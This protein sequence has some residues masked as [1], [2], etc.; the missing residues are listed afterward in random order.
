MGTKT[1][2]LFIPWKPDGGH[3]DAFLGI[4]R[5]IM[6]GQKP[7]KSDPFAK[8]SDFGRFSS[9]KS[10]SKTSMELYRNSDV[11]IDAEIY[12]HKYEP[13]PLDQP[14]LDAFEDRSLQR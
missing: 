11:D 5:A 2:Y 13:T 12:T 3:T 9:R 14:K 6:L 10:F 7:I 4:S 1:I 8:G